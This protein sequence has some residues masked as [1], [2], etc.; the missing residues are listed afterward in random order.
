METTTLEVNKK[1]LIDLIEWYKNSYHKADF[2]HTD[3]INKIKQIDNEADLEPY[4]QTV[5]GWID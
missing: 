4:W 1:A 3:M 2:C 5:D